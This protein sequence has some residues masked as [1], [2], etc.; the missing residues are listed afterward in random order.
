MVRV[1]NPVHLT[2][3]DVAKKVQDLARSKVDQD[4]ARPVA[5]DVDGAVSSKRYRFSVSFSGLPCGVNEHEWH[6][7]AIYRPNRQAV[8]AQGRRRIA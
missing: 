1:Q 2:D 5:D 6:S 7:A 4:A 3:A 8:V